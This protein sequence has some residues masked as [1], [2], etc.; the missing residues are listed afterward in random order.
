MLNGEFTKRNSEQNGFEIEENYI[1]CF[2]G[3]TLNLNDFSSALDSI[4]MF[5]PKNRAFILNDDPQS[6][7]LI[8]T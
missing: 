6:R 2:S 4:E 1:V 8:Q 3:R 7:I 5:S